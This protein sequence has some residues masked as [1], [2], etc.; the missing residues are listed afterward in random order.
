VN[1]E[2][3]QKQQLEASIAVQEPHHYY[4][5]LLHEE[6]NLSILTKH[7]WSPSKVRN[8]LRSCKGG[9]TDSCLSLRR[10]GVLRI[11]LWT[12]IVNWGRSR[13][14]VN[15]VHKQIYALWKPKSCTYVQNAIHLNC[16]VKL[17]TNVTSIDMRFIQTSHHTRSP[18][19]VFVWRWIALNDVVGLIDLFRG[20]DR[21][22]VNQI[23]WKV[24]SCW[25]IWGCKNDEKIWTWADIFSVSTWR[26][27]IDVA[28]SP[29]TWRMFR[30]G[31]WIPYRDR[32]LH[33]DS[34]SQNGV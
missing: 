30:W 22:D 33:K 14:K 19:K 12:W 28:S 34:S 13:N 18:K 26:F 31:V 20:C 10:T 8:T 21:S 1:S 29:R 7:L 32:T 16:S 2:P 27:E 5:H 17:N 9:I 24:G 6:L 15:T 11:Y 4:D 23:F 25:F 3:V